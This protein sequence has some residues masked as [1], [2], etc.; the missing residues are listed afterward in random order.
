MLNRCEEG[1]QAIEFGE[2]VADKF[3]E[4]QE[5]NPVLEV[6]KKY[7][8]EESLAVAPTEADHVNSIYADLI[9]EY[10]VKERTEKTGYPSDIE[11]AE[12]GEKFKEKFEQ[13]FA[14]E[15]DYEAYGR[16]VFETCVAYIRFSEAIAAYKLLSPGGKG[17]KDASPDAEQIKK[18]IDTVRAKRVKDEKK[19]AQK[20]LYLT[21]DVTSNMISPTERYARA[22]SKLRPEGEES[23]PEE[24]QEWRIP[25]KI[26]DDASSPAEVVLLAILYYRYKPKNVEKY[27]DYYPL[28]I[29]GVGIY[30]ADRD[31]GKAVSNLKAKAVFL[32]FNVIP[33]IGKGKEKQSRTMAAMKQEVVEAFRGCWNKKANP[34]SYLT[35]KPGKPRD[36]LHEVSAYMETLKTAEKTAEKLARVPAMDGKQYI[37]TLYSTDD[38]DNM[39]REYGVG[40]REVLFKK[41]DAVCKDPEL[42]NEKNIKLKMPSKIHD[43][44]VLRL[45]L[46]VHWVEKEKPYDKQQTATKE[47]LKRLLEINDQNSLKAIFERL[48]KAKREVFNSN[49]DLIFEFEKKDVD[50][51]REFSY[52]I[53][54]KTN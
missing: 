36:L 33:F 45:C 37:K 19:N 39:V 52:K 15:S 44:C 17:K 8:G 24:E 38:L 53:S 25:L 40:V 51:K 4:S 32:K 35:I 43:K 11:L 49:E 48:E 31:Q 14:K 20:H 50:G 16:V 21:F 7:R 22:L 2:K 27:T 9:A 23:V 18:A 47:E 5:N 13:L 28:S 6:L 54:R 26:C 42:K 10:F 1:K 29:R 41:L 34:Y 3:A 46:A 30:M 12:Y